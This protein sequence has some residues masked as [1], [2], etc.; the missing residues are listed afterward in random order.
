VESGA[1]IIGEITA[2]DQYLFGEGSHY[3]IYK[4]LGAHMVEQKGVKGVGF[5]VWAPHAQSVH[6]VGN[7]NGWNVTSHEMKR[8]GD[9]GIYQLFIPK[10]KEGEVYKYYITT[11]LGQGIYKTDPYGNYSEIRPGTASIVVNLEAFSWSDN[12]WMN[13]RKERNISKEP[14][15]IYEIHLGSWK[16]HE[17]LKENPEGFY[18]YKEL[19][20]ELVDYIKEMGYTH[21]EL[22]GVMEHPYDGS[23]GYQVTGYFAPTSRYGSPQDFMYFINYF[24][25]NQIGVILDWVPAHFPKDEHG[26]A[27]FDGT[28]LYEYADPKMGE[29]A[30]WG[31]K[32]F[33]YG[34]NEVCNFLMGSAL[35]WIEQFHL[36]GLRVD[37]VASM[38]Y[39]DYGRDIGDWI[40]NRYG[41]NKNLEAVE[42]LKHLNSV[43]LKKNKGI[44]MIAEESTT[45]PKVTGEI[46]DGGLG[47][48]FK[49]NMGWMNDFLEYQKSDPYFRQY[50]HNKMTFAMTY[51]YSEKYMLVLSHD[52]VVHL[53]KSMIEKMPGDYNEKFE[54]LKAAYTFM[55]GHPGKKLIFMG[56]EFGQIGEW[57]E[58]R[59]LNWF[60]LQDKN[61]Q[62]LKTFV[63]NLLHLYQNYPALYEQD[64][65]ADGFEWVN[66]DDAHRSIFS[67]IRH[68]GEKEESL[69]F[70]CNFTPVLRA[71][72]CVGVPNPGTYEVILENQEKKEKRYMA[73]KQECDGREYSIA[74]PLK[75]YGAAILKYKNHRRM[76]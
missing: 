26:L 57:S 49:W 25:E 2:F 51:A 42:F 55:V 64:D 33:D 39:L 46:Q 31:T 50:N 44:M 27:Q 73:V 19:A 38:L 14:V 43:I 74:Y 54:N 52:E 29:H 8:L 45:W 11:E 60:L 22:M 47:F 70:I 37:A 71:D 5:A 58:E 4:K 65:L 28:C 61:H 62:D 23:W 34:K 36:D 69:L 20:H 1:E 30:N 72:Y 41:D 3:E 67:F 6:V 13:K 56:Q 10:L 66:A 48:T 12:A 32:V 53:K 75:G 17:G 40:P 35:F 18:N 59:S 15:A 24:H 21:V 63:K 9:G 76:P 68:G 7:F 16:K